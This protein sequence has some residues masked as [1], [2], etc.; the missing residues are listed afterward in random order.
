MSVPS[1]L[2]HRLSSLRDSV[3]QNVKG[4]EKEM[5][6]EWEKLEKLSKDELIIELVHWK[7]LYSILRSEQ[8]DSCDMPELVR[9]D[10]GSDD[11]W[12]PG[13]ITSDLWAEKIVLFAAARAEGLE[14]WPCDV[15]DYG[16]TD[17]QSYDICKRLHEEGRLI[18]PSGVCLMGVR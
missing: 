2:E 14:F 15:M 17:Q 6:S 8:D 9:S 13:E 18:L 5:E 7:T 4:G 11:D 10:A 12:N 16:L 3:V 1:I